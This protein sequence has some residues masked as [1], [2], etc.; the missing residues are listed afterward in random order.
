M[1][2]A[3]LKRREFVTLLG[4]A[5]ATW[6]IAARA[7]QAALPVIGFLHPGSPEAT[8]KFVAGFHKGLGE[9]GYVEGRNVPIEY[10]WAYGESGRLPELA[11]DLISRPVAVIV[12]PGSIA[13]ALAA[14]A[15]T[16]TIPIVHASGTDPV[17]AGLVAS[18]NRP[19]GNVTGVSAMNVGL[20]GKQLGLLHQ[21][22]PGAARFAVLVS[23]GN[24]QIQATIAEAHATGSAMGRQLEILST[25]T[26]RDF[27]AAF[28][29]AVQKRAEALLISPDP[30]F[31]NRLV[32]LA[33]LATRHAMPTVYALREFAEGGGLMSYGSN[34]TDLFRQA[35]I[36]TGRV[37]KGEKPADLP[38]LQATK[39]ELVV[40]LQTAEAL[41]LDVP[42]TLLAL[43]DEVI[44]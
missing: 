2:F 35:G 10:R 14:K 9:T 3:Q 29:S 13:A 32:Q 11:A 36:Y 20:L 34:F 5:A 23:P 38:I 26:N 42:A 30:L 33:T 6:P 17:Q 44:D 31:T 21:L 39:F 43:A 28:S 7:Q 27:A 24:P 12:T 41:G 40:N 37:L 25:R 4:G 16:A 15:A 22:L 19:G 18:L 8:A 1:Q